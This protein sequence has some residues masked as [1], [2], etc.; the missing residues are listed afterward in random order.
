MWCD[1]QLEMM[2]LVLAVMADTTPQ[3]VDCAYLYGNTPDNE[4]SPLMKGVELWKSGGVPRI[5][6]CGGGIYAPHGVNAYNGGDAWE[7]YL[8]KNGVER[9]AIRQIPRPELSHTDTEARNLVFCC[10]SRGWKRVIVTC[11]THQQVRGF[12]NTITYAVRYYP[13]LKVY[14]VPGKPLPWQDESLYSQGNIQGSRISDGVAA[15][16]ERLERWHAKDDLLSC[17]EV[18]DYLKQRDS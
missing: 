7:D 15:E 5:L 6:L 3:E 11:V 8:V 12:V 2:K 1:S 14:S 17:A 4:L 13:E 10:K 16:Y 9:N 18:L